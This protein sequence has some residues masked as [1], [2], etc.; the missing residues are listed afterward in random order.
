MDASWTEANVVLMVFPKETLP[1]FEVPEEAL[2]VVEHVDFFRVNDALIFPP[3]EFKEV[4][5]S[6]IEEGE[7]GV[8]EP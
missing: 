2:D 4:E 7:L 1:L 8:T 6:G 3:A 5:S